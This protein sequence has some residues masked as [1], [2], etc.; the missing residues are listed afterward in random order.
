MICTGQG[1]TLHR[2]PDRFQTLNDMSFFFYDLDMLTRVMRTLGV[3]SGH[4]GILCSRCS[5]VDPRNGTAADSD[6][7]ACR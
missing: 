5:A 1:H 3:S 2:T 7:T 6:F 4:S